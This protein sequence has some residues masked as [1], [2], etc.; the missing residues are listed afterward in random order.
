[1]DF[2]KKITLTEAKNATVIRQGHFDN[3]IYSNKEGTEEIWISR[4]IVADGVDYNNQVTH[5]KL[6]NGNWVETKVYEAL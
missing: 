4:L 1:M 6:I 2:N 5:K 3:L